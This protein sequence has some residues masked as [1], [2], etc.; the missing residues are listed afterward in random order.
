M[1][2]SLTWARGPWGELGYEGTVLTW[3]LLVYSS[4]SLSF[5][6]GK[7][8][9]ACGEGSPCKFLVRHLKSDYILQGG[10][11]T[12][13][14]NVEVANVTASG[15]YVPLQ[16]VGGE[17]GPLETGE[18]RIMYPYRE[19]IETLSQRPFVGLIVHAY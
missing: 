9:A 1:G 4:S 14:E 15:V 11:T 10:R 19:C 18:G 8:H 2:A 5:S 17:V 16:W 12:A 3:D 7:C 6:N 13:A